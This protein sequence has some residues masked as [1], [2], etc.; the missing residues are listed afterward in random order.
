MLSESDV[1]ELEHRQ[2]QV[3]RRYAWRRWS[4]IFGI[5]NCL[6]GCGLIT[7]VLV[8]VFASGRGPVQIEVITSKAVLWIG[9]LFTLIGFTGVAE[10]FNAKALMRHCFL[11]ERK[12]REEQNDAP[13]T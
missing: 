7:A 9:I 13:Q 10:F 1:L 5:V 12:I 11:I 6:I 8:E 4:L 3:A 2:K